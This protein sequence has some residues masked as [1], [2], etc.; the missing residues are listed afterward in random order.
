MNNNKYINVQI[1]E[2]KY[3]KPCF[4]FSFIKAYNIFDFS[5]LTSYLPTCS[6]ASRLNV[7]LALTTSTKSL[8]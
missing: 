1:V 6:T 5:I 7:F 4:Y 8:I 3:N 2:M